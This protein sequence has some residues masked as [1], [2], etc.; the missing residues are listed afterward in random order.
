MNGPGTTQVGI[1]LQ[2]WHYGVIGAAAFI[3][4]AI[5]CVTGLLIKY[6]AGTNAAC[7]II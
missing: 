1:L 6:Q 5:I 4:V 7:I 2:D 3:I